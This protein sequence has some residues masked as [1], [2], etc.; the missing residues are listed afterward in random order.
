MKTKKF[1]IVM[2]SENTNSFGLHEHILMAPD[3]EAWKAG[4]SIGS[5]NAPWLVGTDVDIPL[6]DAGGPQWHKVSVEIPH[7]LPAA[8]PN[9]L[10]DIF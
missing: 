9:V 6:D 1:R 4:R 2:V 8:P 10:K 5:W 3:G 7:R